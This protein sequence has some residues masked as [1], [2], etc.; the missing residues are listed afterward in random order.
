[1]KRLLDA[2][3]GFDLDAF[4]AALRAA[5][6]GERPG[7]AV[8]TLLQQAVGRPDALRAALSDLADGDETLL[9]EDDTV[10]IWHCRF[11]PEREVPPHEHRMPALIGVFAGTE[12]NTFYRR[13]AAGL[14]RVKTRRVAAGEVLAIGDAGIHSVSAAGT[15]PSH[16]VHVYL[17]PLSAVERSLF[18]WQT[19][20]PRPLTDA[21]FQTL[22]RRISSAARG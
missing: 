12:A 3:A 20:A 10:S 1:V 19:G 16:A 5:A 14:E 8:R 6:A 13:G 18:D 4:I 22:T 2:S 15:A 9:F 21:N 7:R 11:H 17:G